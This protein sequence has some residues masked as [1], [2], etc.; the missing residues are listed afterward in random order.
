MNEANVER[1]AATLCRL[2]GAALK[3]GQ[4]LSFND[5][6]VLPP[7]VRTL[8]ER[9]RNGADWMPAW[10]LEESLRRELGDRWREH[11][12]AFDEEP[13]AAASIG[14]VHRATLVDGRRVA[15]KVQYP[16]VS[17]SIVSDLWSMRQLVT[18]TGV[19]PPGL[20]LDRVLEVAREELLEE[21]DY[22]REQEKTGGQKERNP[23][24]AR[25]RAAAL[26]EGAWPCSA[27]P[28]VL[29]T[30]WMAGL[31]IDKAAAEGAIEPAERDRIGER[32]LWLTLSELFKFRFMQT[33]P[34][35]SNFLY[36]PRTR[37]L[38]MIDF[39][40]CREYDAPFAASYLR[41]AQR[42]AILHHSRE[43]G[44][45]TGEEGRTMLDAHTRAAVLVGRP[46][47]D[48]EQPY[49]FGKQT[50]SKRVT[51]DVQTMLRERLTPP[52]KEIY[53]LH[54]RLNACFRACDERVRYS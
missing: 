7:A 38:S 26:L 35:W 4:M 21:C 40:A 22:E 11:V 25:R 3:V 52:R 5:A 41:L 15:I 32:L 1:L 36:E 20:Y 53:S 12:E 18:Y 24:R 37:Q 29:T 39:G 23:G 10:Q 6:D 27:T 46:F 54:R 49:D 44:F 8:M 42:E 51:G 19:V 30:E 28:H 43:L 33:D 14:Q 34:N 9:V 31:P 48:G 2:R 17:D 50:I 45:L 47:A 13:V 16:G